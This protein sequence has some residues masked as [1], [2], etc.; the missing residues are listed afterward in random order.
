MPQIAS[1]S[2]ILGRLFLFLDNF[3]YYHTECPN[4]DSGRCVF[5]VFIGCL[6]YYVTY[7]NLTTHQ[8]VLNDL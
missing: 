5:L 6:Q 7:V 4:I 1:E 8:R 3:Y 2:R